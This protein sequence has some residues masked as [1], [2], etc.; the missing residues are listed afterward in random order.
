MPRPVKSRAYDNS[1]RRG[2]SDE[3]RD[4]ILAVSR[5]LFV[6]RGYPR[7]TMSAISERA[8]VALDTVYVLVGRK[9][10][11]FRLLI[12]TAIS[13]ADEA[14]P[15][16]ERDYVRAIRA[17]PSAT[18]KL[19]LYADTLPAIQARLAPL[20]AVLQAAAAAEPELD[21]LWSEVS[22][23]RASNMRRLAAEL[24]ETGHLLVPEPR[25]PPGGCCR[26]LAI[27]RRS[28]SPPPRR[29]TVDSSPSSPIDP[30]SG[31]SRRRP[32]PMAPRAARGR[33]WP[34]TCLNTS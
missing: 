14:I 30:R 15:A 25:G 28:A 5:E 13:G 24:A 8:G 11:L 2:A 16:A 31:P 4:R 3:R 29:G 12:E 22:E 19:A 23:R 1:R 27:V 9:P 33:A 20:V 6:E 10:A 18:G 32:S 17:E 21:Q 26:V 7:T 34:Q